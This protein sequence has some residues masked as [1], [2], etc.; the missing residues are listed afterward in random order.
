M[1]A[2][3][4]A[5]SA[6]NR[7]AASMWGKAARATED[8]RRYRAAFPH[9]EAASRF[10]AL[11]ARSEA[12]IARAGGDD[13]GAIRLLE[14]SLACAEEL[15]LRNEHWRTQARLAALYRAAG[16]T[17]RAESFATAAAARVVTLAGTI[18]EARLREGFLQGAAKGYHLPLPTAAPATAARSR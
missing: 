2:S 8:L 11:F 7:D 4:R 3:E 12:A 6:R 15:D 1:A 9:I 13:A 14:V 10:R 16:E 17:A 5:K 18:P